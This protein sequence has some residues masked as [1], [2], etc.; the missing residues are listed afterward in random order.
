MEILS[1]L[2][3]AGAGRGGGPRSLLSRWSPMEA[4]HHI[5]NVLELRRDCGSV[6]GRRG[7]GRRGAGARPRH[8]LERR[9]PAGSQQ[10]TGSRQRG[11][12]RA[13]G[14]RQRRAVRR[15]P[16]R[17]QPL[18]VDST[19]RRACAETGQASRR[20]PGRAEQRVTRGRQRQVRVEQ[21]AGV[22][23]GGGAEV[24]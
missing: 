6:R 12:S 15:E 22:E 21:H 11:T 23:L 14:G 5:L 20:V 1:I 3:R 7:A 10:L 18:G 13:R 19:R 8:C 16:R 4:I 9:G 17:L 24:R 2:Q